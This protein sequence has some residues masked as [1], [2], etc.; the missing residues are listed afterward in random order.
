ME[1]QG[2]SSS[3]KQ[4]TA[5]V[6]KSNLQ[7]VLNQL[8]KVEKLY[9]EVHKSPEESKNLMFLRNIDLI[10]TLDATV[11]KANID[12]KLC[13]V[14]I[15]MLTLENGFSQLRWSQHF[16]D[17]KAAMCIK[18]NNDAQAELLSC[19][20]STLSGNNTEEYHFNE[21]GLFKER[22]VLYL[23]SELSNNKSMLNSLEKQLVIVQEQMEYIK[24]EDVRNDFTNYQKAKSKIDKEYNNLKSTLKEMTV[25]SQQIL[26]KEEK[27]DK[28]LRFESF[29]FVKLDSERWMEK[30]DEILKLIFEI[31]M[32]L[33][34]K[35]K[36]NTIKNWSKG[37]SQ[38]EEEE[39]YNFIDFIPDDIY[40]KKY[41]LC[42]IPTQNLNNVKELQ[43]K[44]KNMAEAN[45][46]YQNVRV[47]YFTLDSFQY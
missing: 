18:S 19:I 4:V 47:K 9:E 30:I 8:T 21:A 44:I 3:A 42:K 43:N 17:E 12:N 25:K 33:E 26:T 27:A 7:V 2:K 14:K 20:E 11:Y 37:I 10:K 39:K 13:D 45:L 16:W 1:K 40:G 6:D 46:V 36:I 41:E 22:E 35:A 38:Y 5:N 29:S 28:T 32:T 31:D 15:I 34:I 23:F 24:W